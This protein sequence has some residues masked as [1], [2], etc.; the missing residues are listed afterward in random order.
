MTITES[1]AHLLFI[2]GKFLS[3]QGC[4]F[5][6][7]RGC[8]SPPLYVEPLLRW[9]FIGQI[10]SILAKTEIYEPKSHFIGQF[11]FLLSK[12]KKAVGVSSGSFL[13]HFIRYRIYRSSFFKAFQTQTT[14]ITLA[15]C[16]FF[17]IVARCR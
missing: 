17:T 13:L 16:F 12:T 9:K 1:S 4:G 15:T 14:A 10:L 11:S 8:L 2:A 6:G 7:R 3:K 5:G